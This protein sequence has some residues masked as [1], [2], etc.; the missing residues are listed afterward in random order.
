MRYAIDSHTGVDN[1]RFDIVTLRPADDT[2]GT[3]AS[4]P[5]RPRVF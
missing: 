1:A 4:D 5:T 3:V 2:T